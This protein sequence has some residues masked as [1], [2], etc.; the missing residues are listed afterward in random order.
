MEL[1]PDLV[2]YCIEPNKNLN[3]EIRKNLKSNQVTVVN[4]LASNKVMP[5]TFNIHEDSQMS[6]ILGVEENKLKKNF[7]WDNPEKI[8]KVE[9]TS[10]T[11]DIL[12]E[13]HQV[14][15]SKKTLLKIDTQGNELDVLKGA[16]G[17]LPS[18]HYIIVEYMFDS[19]YVGETSSNDLFKLLFDKGFIFSGPTMYA[20]R[21]DG[22]IGAINFLFKKQQG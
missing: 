17:C 9:L 6:S 13:Q 7:E 14:D 11:L 19:P 3:T 12:C 8:E 22:K 10:S 5:V 21:V 2:F 4:E 1:F 20:N 18:F 16:S 15:L